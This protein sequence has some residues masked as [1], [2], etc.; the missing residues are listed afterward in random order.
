[1]C[2]QTLISS[3]PSAADVFPNILSSSV[4]SAADVFPNINF[5]CSFCCWCVPKHIKFQCSF[6]YR[7]TNTQLLSAPHLNS[8]SALCIPSYLPLFSFLHTLSRDSLLSLFSV[9]FAPS[10]AASSACRTGCRISGV[11]WLT[12]LIQSDTVSEHNCL[13][14]YLKICYLANIVHIVRQTYSMNYI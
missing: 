10:S 11:H 12:S 9:T 7:S 8:Q 14:V 13:L 1:M 3:V 2:S 4:P 6:S 5:Q